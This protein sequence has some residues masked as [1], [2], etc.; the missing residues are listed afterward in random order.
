MKKGFTL[1]ELVIVMSILS[2]LS[3][4]AMLYYISFEFKTKVRVDAS[5]AKIYTNGV[6][7]YENIKQQTFNFVNQD[8]MF[9]DFEEIGFI[10]DNVRSGPQLDLTGSWYFDKTDYIVKAKISIPASEFDKI[11]NTDKKYFY[12]TP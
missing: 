2:I 8:K 12:N 11:S 7:Y 5:N 6:L 1:I 3:S 9:D 10:I 4:F